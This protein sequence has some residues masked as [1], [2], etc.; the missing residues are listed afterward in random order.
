MSVSAS[1]AHQ[2]ACKKL[3]YRRLA[4]GCLRTPVDDAAVFLGFAPA[5]TCTLYLLDSYA[6]NVYTRIMPAKKFP[7][8]LESL[9]LSSQYAA[10]G[11]LCPR[12]SGASRPV[13]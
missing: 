7:H 8:R 1:E 5:Y 13:C 11:T 12:F 10:V 9:D 4:L 2:T 3:K 6:S